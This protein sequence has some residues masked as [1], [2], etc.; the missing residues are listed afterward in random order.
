MMPFFPEK[1]ENITVKI[2]QSAELKCKV[3]N[4]VNY[5]VTKKNCKIAKFNTTVGLFRQ[6]LIP[7]E[8]PIRA[9]PI[10]L[11]HLSLKK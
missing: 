5:K 6:Y 8:M 4:L 7:P 2:G 11:H 3:E 9:F 10:F 1:V